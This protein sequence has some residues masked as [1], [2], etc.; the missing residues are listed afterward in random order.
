MNSVFH[1]FVLNYQLFYFAGALVRVMLTVEV[2]GHLRVEGSILSRP[3]FHEVRCLGC[4]MHLRTALSRGLLLLLWLQTH[5]L[6]TDV[7]LWM[8]SRCLSWLVRLPAA[9]EP[10]AVPNTSFLLSKHVVVDL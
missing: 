3:L 9:G 1:E 4:F 5:T 2:I 6:A 10:L 7:V 8:C